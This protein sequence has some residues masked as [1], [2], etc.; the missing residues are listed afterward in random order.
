MKDPNVLNLEHILQSLADES[1]KLLKA[2]TE[3]DEFGVRTSMDRIRQLKSDIQDVDAEH[4]AFFDS[5]PVDKRAKISELLA[6]YKKSE[7]FRKAWSLRYSEVGPIKVIIELPD[8]PNGILD[9]V[10]PEEWDWNF[11]IMCLAV[12]AISG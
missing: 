5:Q 12:S 6:I 4:K 1:E 11:D 8:G 3:G 7:A 10:I 2:G 9:M